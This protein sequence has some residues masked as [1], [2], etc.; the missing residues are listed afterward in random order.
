MNMIFCLIEAVAQNSPDRREY[1]GENAAHGKIKSLQ[2]SVIFADFKNIKT[3]GEAVKKRS[4]LRNECSE[5]NK[6]EVAVQKNRFPVLIFVHFLS[7]CLNI[8]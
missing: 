7:S 1:Q 5:K 2:K 4:D 8:K 3:D 6:I